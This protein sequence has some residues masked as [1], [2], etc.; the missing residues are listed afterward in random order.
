MAPV[1]K[2]VGPVVKRA[3]PVEYFLPGRAQFWCVVAVVQPDAA[4]A[5]VQLDVQRVHLAL[6]EAL[7]SA[8]VPPVAQPDAHFEVVRLAVLR[9]VVRVQEPHLGRTYRVQLVCRVQPVYQFQPVARSQLAVRRGL[10]ARL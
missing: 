2:R 3:A 1:V 5:D 7:V 9:A 8:H 4:A 10:A 6:T